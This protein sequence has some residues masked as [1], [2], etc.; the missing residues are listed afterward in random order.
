M[1]QV[2]WNIGELKTAIGTV[3]VCGR[4]QGELLTLHNAWILEEDGIISALGEGNP[5]KADKSV[6]CRAKLVTA[7][8]VD[9]HTHLVFGGWREH[10]LAM[11]LAGKS[12]LE[13]LAAGGGIL[14]TV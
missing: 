11:K 12:Y 9:C 2:F 13:I 8:L 3:A 7:G 1:K 5:P 4:A 14:S 6:D 10:E